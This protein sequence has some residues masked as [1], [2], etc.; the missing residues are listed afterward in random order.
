ML[1][2]EK[3]SESNKNQRLIQPSLSLKTHQHPK[4][5]DIC[6]KVLS[7]QS[8]HTMNQEILVQVGEKSNIIQA[9]GGSAIY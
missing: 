4:Y 7:V 3:P 6:A 1:D 2:E 5:S 8:L 9:G